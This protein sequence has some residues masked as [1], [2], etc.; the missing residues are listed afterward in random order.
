MWQLSYL[1]TNLLELGDAVR[2]GNNLSGAD[3]CEVQR[4]EEQHHIPAEKEVGVFSWLI[5]TTN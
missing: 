2:E 5:I 1:Y 3:K 4:V